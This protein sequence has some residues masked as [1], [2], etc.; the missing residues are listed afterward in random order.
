M[1]CGSKMSFYPR[2]DHEIIDNTTALDF[3]RPYMWIPW[4]TRMGEI[5]AMN[6]VLNTYTP[7]SFFVISVKHCNIIFFKSVKINIRITHSELNEKQKIPTRH[8][9]SNI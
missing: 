1:G 7:K 8:I 4:I 2:R 9:Y 5:G 3:S 6:V